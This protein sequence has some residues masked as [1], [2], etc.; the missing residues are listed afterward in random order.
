MTSNKSKYG[1]QHDINKNQH[2]LIGNS[3]PFHPDSLLSIF[4][5][6]NF[7]LEGHFFQEQPTILASYLLWNSKCPIQNSELLSK[8]IF[9]SGT[10][11]KGV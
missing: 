10:K 4:S 2:P 6:K 5:S 8:L 3:L 1:S 11:F 9:E 7:R